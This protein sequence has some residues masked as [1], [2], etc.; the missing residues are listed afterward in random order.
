MTD[1]LSQIMQA[2]GGVALQRVGAEER[3][4][5]RDMAGSAA[6][7][8]AL[9]F[10]R[11]PEAERVALVKA[12]GAVPEVCG[13]DIPTAPARG[14]VRVFDFLASYPKGEDG[15]ELK[16]AGFL[17]RRTME[18][19]DVFGRMAAQSARRGGGGGLTPSQ[20]A[21]GRLYRTLVEDRDA[22]AVRGVSV[23]TRAN[24]GSRG[25]TLEGFT[26]AR[27]ALS[28]RIDAMQAA[29]GS[30][31]ALVPGRAG[32]AQLVTARAL[33]DLVC[34][35]DRDLS[36]VLRAHGW[37]VYGR[38]VARAQGALAAALERMMRPGGRP[39]RL[40]VV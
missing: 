20:V 35:E 33:V 4:A 40:M 24:V 39:A 37:A 26:D 5:I 38:S 13:D 30:G 6:E 22:G 1:R 27:L 16:P 31:A 2:F 15:S 32:R 25:G 17:G 28:R 36:D 12:A 7:A 18:R 29:V 8:R 23:E 10:E 34:L 19:L 9:A 14:A 3:A 11:L 21:I